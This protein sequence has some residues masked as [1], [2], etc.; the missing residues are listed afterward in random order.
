M[1]CRKHAVLFVIFA[2]IPIWLDNG[3]LT[4]LAHILTLVIFLDI[5]GV[6][7]MFKY[8]KEYIPQHYNQDSSQ[9]ITENGRYD[10]KR[11]SKHE[12]EVITLCDHIASTKYPRKLRAMGLVNEAQTT[13]YKPRYVLFE[14]VILR[15]ASS[16]SPLDQLAVAI[17]YQSKGAAYRRS[18]IEYFEKSIQRVPKRFLN[19]FVSWTNLS[20]YSAFSEVY[21]K[22]HLYKEAIEYAKKAAEYSTQGN[23]YFVDRIETL[24]KK[25]NNPPKRR[26]RKQS[27]TDLQLDQNLRKAAEWFES[28]YLKRPHVF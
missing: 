7:A 15:Y 28:D 14:L 9:S 12:L 27:E 20:L 16:N 17:A 3:K 10:F 19:I 6:P 26:M 18:A 5:R 22:E 11:Y 24:R 8:K 23:P 4:V 21:E 2:N 25:L 1:C 13:V